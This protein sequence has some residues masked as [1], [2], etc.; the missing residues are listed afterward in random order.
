MQ[1]IPEHIIVKSLQ[2]TASLEEEQELNNWFLEDKQNMETYCHLQEIW[3]SRNTMTANA[4][5]SEWDRLYSR[6]NIRPKR[7]IPL[8][9]RYAAAVCVGMLIMFTAT[10]YGMGG[11]TE[12]EVTLVQNMVF[13]QNGVQKIVLPDQSIVWLNE[14]SRISYPETFSNGKRVVS[15]E[16]KAFFEVH[17]NTAQPFIVQT[18]NLEI[19]VTGTTFHVQDDANTVASVTLVTGGVTVNVKGENGQTSTTTQLKP[20]QQACIDKQSNRFS[21]AN[22]DTSFYLAWKDGTYR[23]TDEP[24]EAI[25][26][27]LSR[28]YGVKIDIAPGVQKKRFTGRITPEHTIRDVMEIINQSNPIKYKI[29][30]GTVYISDKS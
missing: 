3:L 30:T 4:I 10:W 25:A 20:G 22:V 15:I 27:Q 18:E 11:G 24:L 26:K 29:E 17:K 6:M 28:H 9:I 21:V 12:K 1:D 13:N 14:N 2:H 8:W 5:H 23:F 19:Q 16:G 7:V